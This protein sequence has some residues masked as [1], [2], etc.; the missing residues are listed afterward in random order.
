MP[1]TIKIKEIIFSLNAFGII[2]LHSTVVKVITNK[3]HQITRKM[4][5]KCNGQY[6]KYEE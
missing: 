1:I 4:A 5:R 2:S 3:N 6:R